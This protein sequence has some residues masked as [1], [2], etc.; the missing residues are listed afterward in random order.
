VGRTPLHRF[1]PAHSGAAIDVNLSGLTG[2]QTYRGVRAFAGRHLCRTTGRPNELSA[3]ARLHLYVMDER[4]DRDASNRQAVA[5]LDRRILSTHYRRAVS[6]ALRRQDVA[7]LAVTILD[8]CQMST[9][10]RIVFNALDNTRNSVL[11]ALEINNSI[12]LFVT[13]TTV[14]NRNPAIVVA[15]ARLRLLVDQRS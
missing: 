6:D 7:A 12:S 14:T 8:Q 10:V 13:T 11:V 4:A 15:A 9:A 2:P 1:A 3:F 5:R